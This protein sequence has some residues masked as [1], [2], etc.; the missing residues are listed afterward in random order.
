VRAHVCKCAFVSVCVSVFV[1]QEV[2]V[3]G[4]MVVSCLLTM[5]V[6]GTKLG[7]QACQKVSLPLSYLAGFF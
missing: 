4:S 2:E 6:L 1:Y 3:R 7:H 5:W